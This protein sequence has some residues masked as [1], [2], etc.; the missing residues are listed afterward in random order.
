MWKTTQSRNSENHSMSV[1]PQRR[2]LDA[3]FM[4]RRQVPNRT[5][6]MHLDLLRKVCEQN[7]IKQSGAVRQSMM[8]K[9]PRVTDDDIKELLHKYKKS[10]EETTKAVQKDTASMLKL[11][12]DVTK[13]TST[14]VKEIYKS[15]GRTARDLQKLTS[16]QLKAHYQHA[17]FMRT[18]NMVKDVEYAKF[19]TL[20]MFYLF[21]LK[22]EHD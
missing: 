14:L 3:V 16:E 6:A 5:T 10:T 18:V 7:S 17:E 22:D 12:Q 8:P 20:K 4:N 21:R 13:R 2:L 11:R 1:K 9:V 19:D 15:E